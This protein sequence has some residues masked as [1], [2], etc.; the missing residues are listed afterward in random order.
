MYPAA[1]PV[2]RMQTRPFRCNPQCKFRGPPGMQGLYFDPYCY[3]PAYTE[4]PKSAPE[5][6]RLQAGSFAPMNETYVPST[7]TIVPTEKQP[8]C[9]NCLQTL[10][11]L[12]KSCF[13][14]DSVRDSSG[15]LVPLAIRT[16]IPGCTL[17]AQ[18]AL[19]SCCSACRPF[20]QY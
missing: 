12:Q 16:D 10:S 5:Y 14:F 1:Q 20:K 9:N 6:R 3:Q 4:A 8:N 18:D 2:E 13:V 17:I 11:S 15:R 19:K 7:M